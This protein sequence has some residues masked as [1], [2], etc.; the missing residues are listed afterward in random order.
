[1]SKPDSK[2]RIE[3]LREAIAHH[4]ELYYRQATPEVSDREYDRLKDELATLEQENPDLAQMTSPSRKVGDD[5]TEGF[6]KVRH[7]QPMLSLDNTYSDEELRG[8]GER[9]ERIFGEETELD[10]VVEPKIDGVAVSLT[11]DKGR[12]VQALTR[13]N[14]AEGDEITRNILEAVPSLPRQLDGDC[15]ELVEIRGELYMTNEEFLR[16]NEDR[17]EQGLPLFANPRNLTA[18]TIKQINGVAGRRLEIV[19]YGVGFCQPN[20]FAKQSELHDAIRRW[21]LPTIEK[22]WKAK[23]IGKAWEAIEQ[24]DTLR[25]SFAYATDGAVVKLDNFEMQSEAGFTSKA[26]RWAIAYKFEAEQAE[27]LL[28][29]IDVQI[30]RTGVV[31]PVAHLAPVQLAGT[32]VSRATLHNEDEISRKDI[33]PGDTVVVQKAGEIIPQVL[34]V[35]VDKRPADSKPFSFAQYLE[36]RSIVA[37]RESGQAAW[38]LVGNEDP[39]QQRIRIQFFAS[40]QCLDIENLGEAVV[41]QLVTAELIQDPADLYQL[42]REQVLQL[43]RFGERSASNLIDAIEKSKSAELWRLLHGLGI[44][45][46]G[47]Q[48]AKDLA[49]QFGS[50]DQLMQADLEALEAIDGVGEIMA[51]AISAF[52]QAETNRSLIE[53]LRVAGLN[54]SLTDAERP[55]ATDSG[56]FAGKTVVLTGTLPSLSRQEAS[57]LI[58]KAGGKASGSVSK[59]TD[60]V[61]AGESAGSKLEKAQK[62]GVTIL[63]EA[64][65]L[66]MLRE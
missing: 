27:T 22:Y 44:P 11:Y 57:A 39:T 8:F 36:E 33:R 3:E 48:S 63:D 53:R 23:G 26:P 62:L 50:L 25:H 60:F 52:F 40:K 18:G 9:L 55:V 35:V 12:L 32:T 28:E 13:G 31:T 20:Y 4:D 54:F 14:G 43:E 65:F 45:H 64:A 21:K 6:R 29:K 19:L 37:E 58:E 61:L 34:R 38:R 5:R 47:K 49:I 15:P 7:R 24:L 41:D 66:E 46:V 1:M 2:S 56:V 17:E 59:K 42:A 51:R 30:G 10:Y 16:I